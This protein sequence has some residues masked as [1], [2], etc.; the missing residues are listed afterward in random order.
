MLKKTKKILKSINFVRHYWTY[1]SY[2]RQFKK[3]LRI[4]HIDNRKTEGED[5]YI[6]KWKVLSSHVEPYSY[7]FFSKYCGKTPNIVPED[8][9]RSYIEEVLNPIESR[10][11]F[12]DK[13][14]F[15]RIVGKEN[16]PRTV[17]CRINGSV[18]LDDNYL[19]AKTDFMIYA[20]DINELILKP[21]VDSCSGKGIIKFIK[22]GD[23]FVSKT[24]DKIKLTIDFL[25]QYSN[26][27]C[28]QEAVRQH[29]FMNQLCTT[30]VNTIRLCVY[31]SVKDETVN[32][33]AS[34][35]R[36]GRDGSVVDNAHAG[37]M[38]AG[39]NVKNGELG[40]F[41]IDQYGNKKAIWNGLDY[42]NNNLTVPNWDKILI[43]AKKIGS[44]ILHH[45]L[46]AM[47]IAI[48]ENGNP[49]L[50]EY[51]LKGFSYWLYQL[52]GQEALGEYTNEIIDYCKKKKEIQKG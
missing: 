26:D 44:T 43:F 11:V 30:S 22:E 1:L 9:G 35:I 20:G 37:G 27:F 41:V 28:L 24:E 4:Q 3:Y 16:C 45:R 29:D 2:S 19:P 18:I 34:I 21:S 5:E 32:I 7:R 49:R 13:N 14:L 42:T 10:S 36:I 52:T 48:D 39:I 15:P 33:I 40:K 51:N 6:K 46:I 12:S 23:Y 31:R 25:N 38:F 17:L 8:I 50:I 47:D